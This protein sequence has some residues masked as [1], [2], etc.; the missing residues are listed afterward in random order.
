M[1]NR[2]YSLAEGT[3]EAFIRRASW[4]EANLNVKREMSESFGA[5]FAPFW[6]IESTACHPYPIDFSRISSVFA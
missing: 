5:W 3:S 2:S 4:L 6:H 1:P